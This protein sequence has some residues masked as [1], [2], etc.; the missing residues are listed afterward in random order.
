[1][2][3]SPFPLT[4]GTHSIYVGT[5]ELLVAWRQVFVFIWYPLFK[6]SCLLNRVRQFWSIL[7]LVCIQADLLD[8]IAQFI[9]LCT[10]LETGLMLSIHQLTCTRFL[11]GDGF[12][13]GHNLSTIDQ[14][15]ARYFTS[16]PASRH[17]GGHSINATIIT[18]LMGRMLLLI[19]GSLRLLVRRRWSS[20]LL[21]MLLLIN[22]LLL[23]FRDPLLGGRINWTS[24]VAWE[25]ALATIVGLE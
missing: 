5:V 7:C 25:A 23:L 9:S 12:L 11:D 10:L 15:G 1:M 6:R 21:A 14:D 2:L 19:G 20:A 18:M 4:N 3:H 16:L 22:W 8:G 24:V 13:S 17:E